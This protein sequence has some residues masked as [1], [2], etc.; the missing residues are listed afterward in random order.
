MPRPGIGNNIVSKKRV[1]AT[2]WLEPGPRL[3]GWNRDLDC[4]AGTGTLT[5]W[6]EPGP[7]LLGWNRDLDSLAGTGTLTAWLEPGP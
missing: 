1:P 2:A 7:Q 5:A 6:L 4:L 3:L